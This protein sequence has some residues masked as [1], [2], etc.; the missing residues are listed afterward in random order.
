MK[1]NHRKKKIKLKTNQ[2]IKLLISFSTV[3]KME[4]VTGK[5]L[6]Q[7]KKNQ[8]KN[9]VFPKPQN[10]NLKVSISKKK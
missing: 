7:K 8:N 3:K 5:K 9:K 6:I 10:D 2:V 4:I 1:P